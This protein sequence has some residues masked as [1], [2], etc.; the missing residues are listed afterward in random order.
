MISKVETIQI[1]PS[2]LAADFA[3]L[4]EE[5]AAAEA[6]GADLLHLDIMDGHFVPNITVGPLVVEA[7]RRATALP[8]NVHLMI[9]EPERYLANFAQ[10]GA[11]TL[12]VHVEA[13]PDVY[14]T[15]CIIR[16]LGVVPGVAL[17]PATPVSS[18]QEVLPVVDFVLVMT[19]SPGFGGQPFI[20]S[21]IGKLH[22]LRALLSELGAR[23]A[24]GVDGGINVQ[25]VPAVVA[26]G[27][28]ILIAGEAIFGA[29]EGIERAIARLR[30]AAE[31]AQ[32][33]SQPQIH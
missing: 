14:R 19:V 21:M 7:V 28:T 6:G 27:A 17:N 29:S 15:L 31:E 10:A 1:A 32:K 24:I 18:L 5:V 13:C 16:E 9:T 11:D 12:S 20:P 23:P 8:L 26:A 3:R 4:G 25:T 30:Q 22:R 2:L 33:D